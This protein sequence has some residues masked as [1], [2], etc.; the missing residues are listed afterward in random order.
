MGHDKAADLLEKTLQEEEDTDYNLTEIAE[1]FIN[2][3]A[4][5]ED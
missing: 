5:Q 1:T 4:E 2:F 3:D